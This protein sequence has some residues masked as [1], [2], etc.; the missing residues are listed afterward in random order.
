[1]WLMDCLFSIDKEHTIFWCLRKALPN[2]DADEV[3]NNNADQMD[4]PVATAA[5]VA[6][7][8]QQLINLDRPAPAFRTG[9]QGRPNPAGEAQ[10]GPRQK[11]RIGREKSQ[12]V[13]RGKR[14]APA[15]KTGAQGGPNPA[16]EVQA[17]PCQ[18]E[19]ILGDKKLD[20]VKGKYGD[21]PTSGRN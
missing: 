7:G 16:D 13:T 19:R 14:P 6:T 10:A 3:D 15:F 8:D 5:V 11:E 20:K 21:W 2:V 17:I 4:A 12:R 18:K 9:A 1:M